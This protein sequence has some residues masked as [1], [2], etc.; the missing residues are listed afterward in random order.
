MKRET[1][2]GTWPLLISGALLLLVTPA[3]LL[4]QVVPSWL[5]IPGS[6]LFLVVAA[7]A[8][9][10]SW[11]TWVRVRGTKASGIPIAGI[12]IGIIPTVLAALVLVP[13]AFD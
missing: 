6:L 4:G 2:I 1:P 9:G 10:W 8:L 12:A 13:L 11:V 3:A 5:S 7:F